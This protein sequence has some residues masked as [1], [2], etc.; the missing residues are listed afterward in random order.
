MTR[1][2]KKQRH[3]HRYNHINLDKEKEKRERERESQRDRNH[4]LSERR[5]GM[6]IGQNSYVVGLRQPCTNMTWYAQ[7]LTVE[8][9]QQ[10][11]IVLR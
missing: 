10:H 7:Q 4:S 1:T 3:V 11:N 8:Y 2:I 6:G 9:I 5:E